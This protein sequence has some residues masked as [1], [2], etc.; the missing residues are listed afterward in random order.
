MREY[1]R[2]P[3]T[4]L[5]EILEDKEIKVSVHQLRRFLRKTDLRKSK[6]AFIKVRLI[7]GEQ[8][9]VDWAHCGTIVIDG[10]TRK[11]SLFAMVLSYSRLIFARFYVD[12]CLESFLAAHQHAFRFFCGVPDKLLYDNLKTAVISH[13]GPMIV[14]NQDLVR[15]AAKY[16]FSLDACNPRSGWE[17]GRV[18]RAIRYLK[19]SFLTGRSFSDLQ[20]ANESL[21][22][23]LRETAN[24]RP[25]PE[26]REKTV[27]QVW[28]E[29]EKPALR[30]TFLS[31]EVISRQFVTKV[32]KTPYIRF[33]SNDYSVPHVYV[34]ENVIV[35]ASEEEVRIFSAAK[36]IAKHPRS[37]GRGKSIETREHV[38]ALLKE[39]IAARQQTRRH[40]VYHQLPHAED[41]LR[42][43]A[44][45]G[46][47]VALARRRIYH[48]FEKHTL[49]AIDSAM[50]ETLACGSASV[51]ALE[52]FLAHHVDETNELDLSAYPALC[53]HAV[54]PH[55]L[56][57]YVFENEVEK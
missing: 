46:Q 42:L 30:K 23:W 52:L 12:Q 2:M 39:R 27:E 18:E 47:N 16:C 15:F 4:R 54:K 49:E 50:R 10:A 53:E 20:S 28:L 32:R 13:V 44:E 37:Y 19:E 45:K 5:V 9:Q 55:N 11:L 56:S 40:L 34:Q 14:F 38:E 31:E 7:E 43:L 51:A 35:F 6:R 57:A 1:P 36:E 3:R 25:W 21:A 8:A 33:D 17:K 41:F 29:K 26:G 48:L 22:V 24:R